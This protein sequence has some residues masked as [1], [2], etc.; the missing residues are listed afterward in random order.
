MTRALKP[1]PL[2]LCPNCQCDALQWDAQPARTLYTRS[3]V[4][5]VS[6][7]WFLRC[8][9]CDTRGGF[10]A[11]RAYALKLFLAGEYLDPFTSE[12]VSREM[13]ARSSSRRFPPTR[14][15][16]RFKPKKSEA[17]STRLRLRF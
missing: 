14:T 6:K 5:P 11:N 16:F 9:K 1:L 12:R 7:R 13:S 15:T 4:I 3:G 17:L 8:A 2:P 10:V